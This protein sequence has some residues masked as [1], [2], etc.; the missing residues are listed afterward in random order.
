MIRSQ[1]NL[2]RMPVQIFKALSLEIKKI[3]HALLKCDQSQNVKYLATTN[4][5]LFTA[6]NKPYIAIFKIVDVHKI[7]S[8]S[9]QGVKFSAE[10]ADFRAI[11]AS[12]EFSVNL[13][14]NLKGSTHG[15][16]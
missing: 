1:I 2:S 9:N 13:G 5:C 4:P 12:D 14:R 3:Y 10:F 6:W 8:I 16:M 11:L 7:C 15:V